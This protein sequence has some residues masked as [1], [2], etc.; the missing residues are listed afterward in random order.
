MK[1]KYSGVI[2]ASGAQKD[3]TPAW[4]NDSIDMNKDKRKLNAREIVYWYNNHPKYEQFEL[5]LSKTKNVVIIGN[6][7]VAIDISRILLRSASELQET[8]IS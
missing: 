4:M 8:E 6:G 5:D 7:N 2:F 1:D 3:N